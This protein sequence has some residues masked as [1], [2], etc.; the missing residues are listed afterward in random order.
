MKPYRIIL[1]RRRHLPDDTDEVIFH[2][3]CEFFFQAGQKIRF[4]HRSITRDYTLINGP[5]GDEL[6]IC[7]RIVPQ[8][9]FSPYLRQAPIGAPFQISAPFGYF[10]YR[11][12]SRPAVFIA[13]GTGIAP[14]VAFARDGASGFTLLH[15]ARSVEEL[16]YRNEVAAAASTYIPCIS[17]S[18]PPELDGAATVYGGHVTTFLKNRM[19]VAEY[20]FYLCGRGEMIEQSIEIIDQR[21]PRSLVFCERFD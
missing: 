12:S 20:D 21:F 19:A 2:R 18:Q 10:T 15:G 6:A 7:V 14:F 3:P 9:R 4:F 11:P 5:D 13:T 16:H 17:S 1:K 8:G